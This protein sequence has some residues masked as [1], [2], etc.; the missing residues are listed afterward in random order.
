M[1]VDEEH[2][3]GL[4]TN[5]AIKS[6]VVLGFH[7]GVYTDSRFEPSSSQRYISQFEDMNDLY[8]NQET[9]ANILKFAKKD[10][11]GNCDQLYFPYRERWVI[12]V[13]TNQEILELQEIILNPFNHDIVKQDIQQDQKLE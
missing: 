7:S 1:I 12:L 11:S 5:K 8:L 13:V 3:F 2:G 6:D 10:V 4:F 9:R